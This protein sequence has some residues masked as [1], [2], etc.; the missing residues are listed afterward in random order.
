M[1][2]TILKKEQAPM[3]HEYVGTP[4]P[5]YSGT[6]PMGALLA[7]PEDVQYQFSWFDPRV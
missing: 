6:L 7:I 5:G 1:S 3:A 4:I 2:A